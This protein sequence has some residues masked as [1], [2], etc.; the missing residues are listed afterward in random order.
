MKIKKDILNE[1]IWKLYIQSQNLHEM[2]F[3]E[4]MNKKENGNDPQFL[5]FYR[6]AYMKKELDYMNEIT[7]KIQNGYLRDANFINQ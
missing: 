2:T 3:L 4:F 6:N 5:S 1:R 7:E